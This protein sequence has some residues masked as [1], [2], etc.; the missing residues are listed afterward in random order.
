MSPQFVLKCINNHS[1]CLF[2]FPV[3]SYFHQWIDIVECKKSIYNI[4]DTRILFPYHRLTLEYNKMSP[5]FVLKCIN[6]HSLCLFVF[7]VISYF[8]QWID[9]VECK[10]SIYNIQDTRILFPYHRLTLEY[11]KIYI[12]LPLPLFG[13]YFAPN[14]VQAEWCKS[15]EWKEL[16]PVIVVH[17]IIPNKTQWLFSNLAY[18]R[19]KNRPLNGSHVCSWL[20]PHWSIILDMNRH[21]SSDVVFNFK[22]SKTY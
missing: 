16:I 12:I 8:H 22:Y 18:F 1:L 15:Q 6:N 3:I 2:V 10:K 5:Q 14:W 7:P 11:N 21:A 9:I 13:A 19:A 17:T 4:Q 20:Y